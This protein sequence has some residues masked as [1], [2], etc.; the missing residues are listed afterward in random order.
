MSKQLKSKKKRRQMFNHIRQA[1]TEQQYEYLVERHIVKPS[2]KYFSILD[3][4]S[5][6]A[7]NVYN[8]GLYRVRQKLFAGEWMSYGKLDK[9]IKKSN[10]QRDCMLYSSMH[11]VHLVQQVLKLVVQNMTSWRKARKAY[12][13]DCGG[14]SL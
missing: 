10:E 4:F 5:H 12:L 9:S 3:H 13:K 6:L 2:N 8:Q 14:S 7:N 11:S 1:K